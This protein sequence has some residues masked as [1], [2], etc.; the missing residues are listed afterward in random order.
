MIYYLFRHFMN[1]LWFNC[2]DLILFLFDLIWILKF[3]LLLLLQSWFLCWGINKSILI[4]IFCLDFLPCRLASPLELLVLT[5]MV[6]FH[7]RINSTE[8]GHFSD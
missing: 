6:G 1:E 8:H 3:V 5:L 4:I 2:I 7:F